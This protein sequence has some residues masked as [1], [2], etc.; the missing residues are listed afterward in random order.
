MKHSLADIS[1]IKK[2]LNFEPIVNHDDGLKV[3]INYFQTGNV[4]KL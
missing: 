2:N 1:L 4:S 3:A